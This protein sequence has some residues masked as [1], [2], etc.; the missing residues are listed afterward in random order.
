MASMPSGTRREFWE[1]PWPAEPP[2]NAKFSSTDLKGKRPSVGKRASRSLSRFLIIFFT[3]VAATLAWQSYGDATREMIANSY[4][5]FGW[6]APQ[7]LALASTVSDVPAAPATPSPDEQQLKAMT[8]GL[9]AVRQSV[10]QLV[11]HQQEMAGDI[12]KLQADRQ[13]ILDKI[14]SPPPRPAAAPARKPVPPTPTPTP[15][16]SSQPAPVR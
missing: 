16:P 15:V 8:L 2:L 11:A 12:A 14:S 3:G 7:A 6:L 1:D 13:D 10:D 9:A 5:Q 4:P